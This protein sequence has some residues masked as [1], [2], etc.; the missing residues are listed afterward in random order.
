MNVGALREVVTIQRP[1]VVT[2]PI[3]G[4]TE[5]VPQTIAVNVP[6]AV[7][8]LGLGSERVEAGQLQSV[9][10]KR[11]RLRYREDVTE[12]MTVLWRGVTLEIG[13]VDLRPEDQETHLICAVVH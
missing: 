1:T 6:A 10:S 8:S 2:D 3:S 13:L 4:Q 7:E 11:V 12:D 5:G 9:V